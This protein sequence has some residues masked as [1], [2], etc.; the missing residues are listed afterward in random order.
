MLVPSYAADDSRPNDAQFAD[1]EAL[2]PR[3][4][5]YMRVVPSPPASRVYSNQAREF[6]E[7]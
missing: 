5:R 7:R 3:A 1:V 2:E 6:S 4:I